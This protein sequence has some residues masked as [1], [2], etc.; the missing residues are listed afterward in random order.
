MGV[1]LYEMVHKDPP[2]FNHPKV[3]TLSYIMNKGVKIDSEK[4]VSEKLRKFSER[5]LVID[6]KSRPSAKELLD[7]TWLVENENLERVSMCES[8]TLSRLTRKDFSVELDLVQTISNKNNF[9][10]SINLFKNN[11]DEQKESPQLRP[12]T[13][14]RSFTVFPSFNNISTSP[15]PP[16]S[17]GDVINANTVTSSPQLTRKGSVPSNNPPNIPSPVIPTLNGD[18]YAVALFDYNF[19]QENV[20]TF[21]KGDEMKVLRFTFFFLN[22]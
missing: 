7:D 3:E 14:D 1:V 6:Y 10:Q 13:K 2:Y 12:V 15:T 9:L 20:F 11:N 5:C 19:P 4:Q 18:K 17:S 22:F 16:P 21:K 8:T